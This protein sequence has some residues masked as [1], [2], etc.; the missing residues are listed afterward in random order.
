MNK[1]MRKAV[2]KQ[3]DKL[4]GMFDCL[5]GWRKASK[6]KRTVRRLQVRMRALRNKRQAMARQSKEDVVQLIKLGFHDIAFNRV[7]QVVKDEEMVK[8][9]E[10]LD[11]YCDVISINISYIRKRKDLPND[12]NEAV[13]SLVFASARIGDLPELQVVRELAEDRYG[14]RFERVAVDLLP[15]NHV[16]HQVREKLTA[17]TVPDDVRL[18]LVDEIARE[19]RLLPEIV[20]LDYPREPKRD[21]STSEIRAVQENDEHRKKLPEEHSEGKLGLYCDTSSSSFS[22]N[23]PTS[24]SQNSFSIVSSFSYSA[25]AHSSQDEL[26]NLMNRIGTKEILMPYMTGSRAEEQQQPE[27]AM[28]GKMIDYF[29]DDVDESSREGSFQDQRIFK[30]RTDEIADYMDTDEYQT[31]RSRRRGKSNSFRKRSRKRSFSREIPELVLEDLM[32]YENPSW[33]R[34]PNPKQ[35]SKA[36]NDGIKIDEVSSV[37]SNLCSPDERNI[38]TRRS[39]KPPYGRTMSM[40]QERYND[41]PENISRTLSFPNQSPNH[42]H[43]KLPDYDDLAAKFRALKK[44]HQRHRLY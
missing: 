16:N 32:Y 3:S 12:I 13:S 7:E 40:P 35:G 33:N 14:P 18:R 8:V 1:L 21:E 28:S 23:L 15:G 38:N 34:P 4:A 19:N 39:M 36:R 9:Y 37:G 29:V 24:S 20:V 41:H 30:F 43:P 11:N 10:L 2:G 6:C 22:S 25:L 17:G 42:V 26:D 27:T 31:I 5:L 44:E